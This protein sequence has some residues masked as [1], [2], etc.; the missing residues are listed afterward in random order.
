MWNEPSFDT[1]KTILTRHDNRKHKISEDTSL[2][3]KT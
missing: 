1:D 3:G 2:E